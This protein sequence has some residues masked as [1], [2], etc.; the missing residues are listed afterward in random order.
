MVV[1]CKLVMFMT[2]GEGTEGDGVYVGDCD[3]YIN[4]NQVGGR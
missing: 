2:K 3:V 4:Y 1:V